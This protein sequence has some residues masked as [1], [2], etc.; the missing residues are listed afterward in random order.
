[1][2]IRLL[3]ARELREA[4]RNR[5]L[6]LYTGLF[7]V[8][9]ALITAVGLPDSQLYGYLGL[10]K[11]MAGLVHLS[12]LL[13]PLLALF[14]A[15]T[16]VAGERELGTLEYLLSHPLSFK[17]VLLGKWLGL[18]TA[19]FLAVTLGFGGAG[20]VAALWGVDWRLVALSYGHILLLGEV[21]IILGLLISRFA[22]SRSQAMTLAV[23]LWLFLTGL[24]SLGIIGLTI[25]WGVPAEIL[26]GW[27]L[28]NPVEAFRLGALSLFD[29][30]GS[31]L[32]PV[33]SLLSGWLGP[34]GLVPAVLASLAL[35]GALLLAVVTRRTGTPRL[36]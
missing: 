22:R 24:G 12:L 2:E 11:T 25:R 28:L 17:Q 32:G 35:W 20:G 7:L 16:S 31:V 30:D 21:F 14:P 19:L 13:V 27:S 26:A 33:G 6:L 15:T 34:R 4:L 23:L 9:A 3:A 36:D 5:W 1:M 29:Q 8:G 18:S 10:G